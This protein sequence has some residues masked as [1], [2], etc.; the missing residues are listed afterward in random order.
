MAWA[1]PIRVAAGGES[2]LRRVRARDPWV[3]GAMASSGI[4]G[5][6]QRKP[7][8]WH[9]RPGRAAR[10]AE[11]KFSATRNRWSSSPLEAEHVRGRVTRRCV[12]DC[13]VG[14][15]ARKPDQATHE[16]KRRPGILLLRLHA[17]ALGVGD[18]RQPGL[19]GGEAGARTSQGWP[20]P[21]H[22]RPLRIPA[23]DVHHPVRRYL[24]VRQ[25]EFLSVVQEQAC[26]AAR[27]SAWRPPSRGAAR[28]PGRRRS[29]SRPASGHGFP[30][31]RPARP[32]A[33][34]AR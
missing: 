3:D 18:D 2:G 13:S 1:Q 24:G 32:Q 4:G 22:R 29:G 5:E 20:P 34:P 30:G 8:R 17:Q 10:G 23:V 21:R 6:L 28:F 12:P 27:R 33:R 7:S 25:P 14:S 11:L 9:P 26:P 15:R 16:R 31:T 19:R